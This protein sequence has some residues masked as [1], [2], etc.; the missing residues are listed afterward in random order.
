MARD[1]DGDGQVDLHNS[2]ADALATSA[3]FLIDLGYRPGIDWG[4]EV[5]VPDGLRL[6]CWR[7]A[8]SCGR[9]RSSPSAGCERVKG[10]DVRRPGAA[11]VPLCR[12]PAERAEI[13]DDAELPGAQGL[14]FLRQLRALGGAHDRPAEGRRAGSSQDWPRDTKFPNLEQRKAIQQAL[15]ELGLYEGVVDGRIGPVSQAA[16]AKF[17]AARGEVADGFI[18]LESYEELAAATR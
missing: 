11:G 2:L 17:Q 9:S 18:T 16:Y 7:R 8:T 10:R 14:Q 12:R 6:L 5:A 3:K 4:F 13:P 1:G 15:I